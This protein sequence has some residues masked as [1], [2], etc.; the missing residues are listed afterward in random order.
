MGCWHRGGH[1]GGTAGRAGGVPGRAPEASLVQVHKGLAAD[2]HAVP[3][4]RPSP[5]PFFEGNRAPLF[6]SHLL[7]ED[8]SLAVPPAAGGKGTQAQSSPFLL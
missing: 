4:A 1:D 8:L 5:V 6:Q 3:Q 7:S 2:S